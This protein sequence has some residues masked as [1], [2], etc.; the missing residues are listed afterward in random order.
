[1]KRKKLTCCILLAYVSLFGCVSL[2][3]NNL[4]QVDMVVFSQL[5]AHNLAGE[6]WPNIDPKTT[7]IQAPD[8]NTYPAYLQALAWQQVPIKTSTLKDTIYR[9][10]KHNYP[11]LL[12]LSWQQHMW[13]A[14]DTKPIHIY[15]GNAYDAS[16]N[17][18]SQSQT[19]DLD[20]SQ[21][22]VWEL[23]GDITI[24]MNRYFNCR[25]NLLFSEPLKTISPLDKNNYF[26]NTQNP[27]IY[28]HLLQT[29]RTRSKEINY[30]DYP[31]Y[32]V[33]FTIHKVKPTPTAV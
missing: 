27:F 22:P 29:R 20:F 10:P 21:F 31:L 12:T 14:A 25:F 28:F 4:Y 16:G 5:N 18:L 11:V 3:D 19:E 33:I 1:M 7:A 8:S 6:Q 24:S 32:G 2:A 30:I 26:A 23:N 17:L 15:G 13:P 9:L